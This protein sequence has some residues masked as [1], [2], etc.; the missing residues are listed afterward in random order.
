MLF[1]WRKLVL[2]FGSSNTDVSNLVQR[3]DHL[4]RK[5]MQTAKDGMISQD[6]N[7]VA[8]RTFD[9]YLNKVRLVADKSNY[10]FN[11]L[12]ALHS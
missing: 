3:F 8:W 7:M 9:E 4:C 1:R 10:H 5:A 2:E 12:N 11:V 6:H